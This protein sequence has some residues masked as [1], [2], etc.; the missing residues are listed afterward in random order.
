MNDKKTKNLPFGPVDTSEGPRASVWEE[1][2]EG[3]IN[4][5]FDDSIQRLPGYVDRNLKSFRRVMGRSVAPKTGVGDILV[6]VRNLASGL[7]KSV[8]GPDFDTTSFTHD[9]LTEAFER[10]VLSPEELET[11]LAR[12]FEEFE[13]EMWSRVADES[14]EM[15]SRVDVEA[16]RT[17]MSKLMEREIAHD[18]LLAQAIRSG[19]KIGV[20]ATLGY[21]LFGR[22]NFS[23]FATEKASELYKSNLNFYNR[24]LASLGRYQVPG[25]VGAVGWAGGVLGSLAIGGIME[26]TLNSV[27]DIKGQYIRQLNTARYVLLYGENPEE[28]EGRGL[29][30]IVRGLERQFERVPALTAQLMDEQTMSDEIRDGEMSEDNVLPLERHAAATDD[31]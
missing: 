10:E 25:W 13:E 8:G 6:G 15:P 26:Y 1:R 19:V 22:L 28:P 7:S 17:R 12:L 9:K 11:L 31:D 30:H 2:F 18:P 14:A 21:V 4:A 29:L 27:R 23:E 5:L 20:P 24:I 3:Q 16:V